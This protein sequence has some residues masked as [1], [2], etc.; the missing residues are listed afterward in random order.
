MSWYHQYQFAEITDGMYPKLR[1]IALPIIRY[2]I[3][4]PLHILAV[5]VLIKG[6]QTM[7]FRIHQIRLYK[8][9]KDLMTIPEE[10]MSESKWTKFLRKLNLRKM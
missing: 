7:W 4:E 6:G 9:S 3:R 1:G 10:I 5:E 2:E 8:S